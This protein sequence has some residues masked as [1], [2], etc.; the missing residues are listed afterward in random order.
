MGLGRR[1]KKSSLFFFYSQKNKK[2]MPVLKHNIKLYKKVRREFFNNCL[3]YQIDGYYRESKYF[4]EA[5]CELNPT[6]KVASMIHQ[7]LKSFIFRE[8]EHRR[9]VYKEISRYEILPVLWKDHKAIER[10]KQRRLTFLANELS[11]VGRHVEGHVVRIIVKPYIRDLNKK[12]SK[13]TALE[14]LKTVPPLLTR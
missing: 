6:D 11:N 7:I 9:G 8:P 12:W 14:K 13:L 4:Q 5:L 2:E 1:L 3:W 10:K